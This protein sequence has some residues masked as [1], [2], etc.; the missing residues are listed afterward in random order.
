M[1]IIIDYYNLFYKYMI[2]FLLMKLIIIIIQV[3][4]SYSLINYPIVS[5][6]K[7]LSGIISSIIKINKNL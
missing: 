2:D 1:I 3:A 5:I 7:I 6:V 4:S